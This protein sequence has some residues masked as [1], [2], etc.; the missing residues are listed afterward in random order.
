MFAFLKSIPLPFNKKIITC[1][2]I[3]AVV[4]A[5]LYLTGLTKFRTKPIW[6]TYADE[7]AAGAEKKDLTIGQKL[8][9]FAKLF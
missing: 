8:D 7:E 4:L 3:I 2:S 1:L 5:I 9:E 6:E